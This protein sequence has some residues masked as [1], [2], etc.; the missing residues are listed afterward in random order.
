MI[1]F[2][3]LLP[4]SW[5]GL[6]L[7]PLASSHELV[8]CIV[9]SLQPLLRMIQNRREKV[10]T[11]PPTFSLN[12]FGAQGRSSPDSC[13]IFKNSWHHCLILRTRMVLA[14][15]SLTYSIALWKLAW[16]LRCWFWLYLFSRDQLFW[17]A[18]LVRDTANGDIWTMHIKNSIKLISLRHTW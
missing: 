16:C 7:I 6:V 1:K 18:E 3:R 13:R 4:E 8:N 2:W 11:L 14:M 10:L 15:R 9:Y 17:G 5:G 12:S